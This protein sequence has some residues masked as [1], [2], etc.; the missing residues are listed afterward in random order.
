ME[1]VISKLMLRH[2]KH[3]FISRLLQYPDKQFL[4]RKLDQKIACMVG[5]IEKLI[6]LEFKGIMVFTHFHHHSSLVVSVLLNERQMIKEFANNTKKKN[7]LDWKTQTSYGELEQ[8]QN[9]D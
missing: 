9:A 8:L 1:I 3:L 6:S 2:E 7:S 5:K 4:T